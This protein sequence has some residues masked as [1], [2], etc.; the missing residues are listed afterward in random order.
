MIAVVHHHHG[1]CSLQGTDCGAPT[2]KS[3]R[4]QEWRQHAE[5]ALDVSK[6]ERS[7]IDVK[8]S[9]KNVSVSKVCLFLTGL[10]FLCVQSKGNSVTIKISLPKYLSFFR[11][12]TFFDDDDCVCDQDS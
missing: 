5:E 1:Q 9:Y 11:S 2:T 12:L 3:T 4:L 6:F 7:G 10:F 8:A